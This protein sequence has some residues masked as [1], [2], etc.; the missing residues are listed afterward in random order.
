MGMN[1]AKFA[2]ASSARHTVSFGCPAHFDEARLSLNSASHVVEAFSITLDSVY[3][4][5]HDTL[6]YS[7]STHGIKDLVMKGTEETRFLKGDAIVFVWPNS[8]STSYGLEV[9]YI[10]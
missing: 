4:S 2:G 3:G 8:D 9:R 1:S 6:L 5:A 10:T 7:Q